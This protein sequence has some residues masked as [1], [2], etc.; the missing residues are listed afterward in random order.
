M[1]ICYRFRRLVEKLV[2]FKF[3]M[4][5]FATVLRCF[6]FIGCAEWL[7]VALVVIMGREAQKILQR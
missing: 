6:N 2:S 3:V 7:T 5:V 4:F 1:M